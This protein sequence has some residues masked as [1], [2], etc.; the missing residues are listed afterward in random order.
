MQSQNF[1][2]CKSVE[3]LGGCRE[4]LKQCKE[5][6]YRDLFKQPRNSPVIFK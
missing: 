2:G 4:F 1:V 3:L 6:I 5:M